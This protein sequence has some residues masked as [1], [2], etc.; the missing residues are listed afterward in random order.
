MQDGNATVGITDEKP[1]IAIRAAVELSF[2]KTHAHLLAFVMAMVLS[3][4]G[5]QMLSTTLVGQI[6]RGSELMRASNGLSP[7]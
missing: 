2:Q 3:G 5:P 7:R 6:E 1:S 4:G